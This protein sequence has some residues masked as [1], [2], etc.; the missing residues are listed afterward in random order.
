MV[1]LNIISK[2]ANLIGNS[3]MKNKNENCILV[4]VLKPQ[5][6]G[7]Y[8]RAKLCGTKQFIPINH[9]NENKSIEEVNI[10][11]KYCWL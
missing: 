5:P 2:R 10:I 7:R 11:V 9:I 3:K 1:L 6:D 4:Q 8:N